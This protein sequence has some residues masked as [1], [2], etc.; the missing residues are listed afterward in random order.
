MQ[1]DN[2]GL[3]AFAAEVFKRDP[4]LYEAAMAAARDFVA[5]RKRHW[6][7]RSRAADIEALDTAH[8]VVGMMK[9]TGAADIQAV[10]DV[11]Q[12]PVPGCRF[13]R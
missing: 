1:K 9:L 10:P 3:Q 5:T 12:V 2:I 8:A 7:E 11:A 4:A 6:L 13:H